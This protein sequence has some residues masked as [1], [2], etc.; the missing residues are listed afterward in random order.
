L[1]CL[2]LRNPSFTGSIHL[3]GRAV[4]GKYYNALGESVTLTQRG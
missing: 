4:S 2:A 1:E 3:D